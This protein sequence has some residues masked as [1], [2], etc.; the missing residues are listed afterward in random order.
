[1]STN[2][3]LFLP[4]FNMNSINNLNYA[5]SKLQQSQGQLKQND[6]KNA[7]STAHESLILA[8]EVVKNDLSPEVVP[9]YINYAKV[10]IEKYLNNNKNL[11]GDEF[12]QC[13]YKNYE[14]VFKEADHLNLPISE[15]KIKINDTNIQKSNI[16]ENNNSDQNDNEIDDESNSEDEEENEDEDEENED[17]EIEENEE[18]SENEQN[19]DS[20]VGF[21][22]KKQKTKPEDEMVEKERKKKMEEEEKEI[23]VQLNSELDQNNIENLQVKDLQIA[24]ENLETARLIIENK[25]SKEKDNASKIE[26]QENMKYLYEIN[27]NLGDILVYA[28]EKYLEG[29]DHYQSCKKMLILMKKED[30]LLLASL[31]M[32]IGEAFSNIEG[33]EKN[34]IDYLKKSIL[35]YTNYL[36]NYLG[37]KDLKLDLESIKTL[38]SNTDD[39]LEI[40]K[41]VQFI[42]EL[43]DDTEYWSQNGEKIKEDIKEFIKSKKEVKNDQKLESKKSDE[44]PEKDDDIEVTLNKKRTKKSQLPKEVKKSQ[45]RKKNK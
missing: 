19:D 16:A 9:F 37:N 25:F 29:I 6:F 45:K 12:L 31:Y 33:S 5:Q 30:S 24:W 44:K 22:G 8:I 43:L 18:R 34:A 21:R 28:H 15:D 10:L 2:Q 42:I 27:L 32:K 14:N 3:S 38:P 36:R 35:I 39:M 11:F 13:L 17:E 1:M 23:K 7:K 4:N 20:L 41:N 26:S 40:K